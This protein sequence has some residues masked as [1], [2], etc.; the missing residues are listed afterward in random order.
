M[1]C[2][3]TNKKEKKSLFN[4]WSILDG[5]NV[6][7]FS[8]VEP[9]SS[10]VPVVVRILE[11]TWFSHHLIRCPNPMAT[12]ADA[13]VPPT[14]MSGAVV[15]VAHPA[16]GTRIAFICKLQFCGIRASIK[17][18]RTK[19]FHAIPHHTHQPD[20]NHNKHQNRQ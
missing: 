3:E 12:C 2:V 8:I 5:T 11:D 18:I 9:T 16:N 14:R 10:P 15:V 20:T 19:S 17:S 13:V 6:V 1:N 7:R 4:T